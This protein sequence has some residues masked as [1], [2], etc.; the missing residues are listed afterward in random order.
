MIF[1]CENMSV[2]LSINSTDTFYTSV[3]DPELLPGS[4]I[5][6]PDPAKSERADN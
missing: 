2:Y 1:L 5:I 3:A 4:G 6:V